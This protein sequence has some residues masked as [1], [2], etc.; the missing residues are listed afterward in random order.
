MFQ[1]T[2]PRAA[3]SKYS[4]TSPWR[5][6]TQQSP[7]PSSHDSHLGGTTF[8]F[9]S[10]HSPTA[11]PTHSQDALQICISLLRRY[12]LAP[13]YAVMW[14]A[15]T[16]PTPH[17]PQDTSHTDSFLPFSSSDPPVTL[18]WD[19]VS[20]PP[21]NTRPGKQAALTQYHWLI[22]LYKDSGVNNGACWPA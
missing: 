3:R 1:I 12:V 15:I 6:D 19:C 13:T 17:F 10:G 14:V 20:P 5:A 8:A 22:L 18:L 2:S 21:P 7:T 9:P 16:H 4:W 11:K